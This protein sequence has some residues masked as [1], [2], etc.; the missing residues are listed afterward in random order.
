M[1]LMNGRYEKP[2]E[3]SRLVDSQVSSVNGDEIKLPTTP[4][5]SGQ[6][7]LVWMT[8]FLF[9]AANSFSFSTFSQFLYI[10]LQRD[11]FPNVTINTT[12]AY[13]NVDTNSTNYL[14]QQDVQEKAAIWGIFL[15]L[16]GGV[17]SVVATFVFGVFT[18]RL[19]RKFLFYLS[20]FGMV[21]RTVWVTVGMNLDWSL[22][23]YIPGYFVEGCTGQVFNLI[24]VSYIYM[25]D[26][27]TVG[28]QRSIGIVMI[29]IAF[30]LA[31]TFP[32]LAVGFMLK[33]TNSFILPFYIS[34]G[35]LAL[36]LILILC[37]PETYPPEVRGK[38]AQ[39]S[40]LDNIKN[41]W[42][43]FCG[44]ENTGRRWMYILTL[45]VFTFTCYDL[46]GRLAMEGLYLLNDPFCWGP[47]E[48][49]I[50]N[51]LRTGLQQIGGM[52]IVVILKKFLNDES[53]A[54]LGS[55]SFGVSF[56][57]E[58]L[59]TTDTM[60]YIGNHI[61]ATNLSTHLIVLNEIVY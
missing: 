28:K 13:C 46:Y 16:V 48:L 9:M 23:M 43:L 15:Y 61:S 45:L 30:G 47:E 51:A 26:I 12:K 25:S 44:Q 20:W 24:Q 53:I 31:T 52:A 4:S 6:Y 42:G 34:L 7:I 60:L 17:P 27:T 32:G 19:G 11:N 22:Y 8:A 58:G 39:S 3:R 49:G 59:A 38:Y 36:T 29:E 54:I 18:D 55:A 57:L 21:F 33:E 1:D 40:R 37:L 2:D 56:V 10:K 14:L 41:S 5:Y 50:F 35:M